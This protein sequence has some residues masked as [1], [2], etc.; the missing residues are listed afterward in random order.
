M[1]PYADTTNY[2]TVPNPSF[3]GIF[4][5]TNLGGT[6]NYFGIFWGSID[7]YNWLDFYNNGNL[8]E[9]ISGSDVAAPANGNQSAPGTNLYVNIFDLPE[10]D[11]FSMNSSNF[12]FEA[13][14]LA[15]GT[16]PV[17]EPA[18]IL[19]FGTGLI[20]LAGVG[21]KKFFKKKS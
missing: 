3:S 10:F 6:Y 9:T 5:A 12:A 1:M 16:A 7:H 2:V 20:G 15:V 11:S 18:T 14:N 21:R 13:D 17:P 4:T 8:V 19:L